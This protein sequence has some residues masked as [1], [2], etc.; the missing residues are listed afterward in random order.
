[1]NFSPA[2]DREKEQQFSVLVS[3]AATIVS[4]MKKTPHSAIVALLKSLK[5]NL[6][7]VEKDKV[8]D[9]LKEEI[10][11]ALEAGGIPQGMIQ[12]LTR[13]FVCLSMQDI[14]LVCGEPGESIILHFK[15]LT[16]E[17]L[18]RLREM[19]LSGLLL[20]LLSEAVKQFLNSQPRV[21]LEVK[22]DD[23]NTCLSCFNGAEGKP[24]LL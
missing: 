18:W 17:S 21:Q 22:R 13:A 6:S 15:C 7:D 10:S 3:E 2:V 1:M 12:D 24:K 16:L 20:R 5:Q 23:F 19:I 11:T 9:R 14:E 8:R 4:R